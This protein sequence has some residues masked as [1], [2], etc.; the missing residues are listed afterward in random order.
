MAPISNKRYLNDQREPDA[1]FLREDGPFL[2]ALVHV[3]TALAQLLDK[4]NLAVPAPVAGLGLIDTGASS[5]CIHEPVLTQLGLNPIG[6][7]TSRTAAGIAIQR[8]YPVRIEFPGEGIDREFNSVAGVDLSGQT[9]SLST[10]EQQIIALIG[11]D[12][13]RNWVLIYNGPI[14]VVTIAF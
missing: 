14:G 1:D 11:R 2:N 9:V 8:L 3:P 5:T 13:M 7:T 4:Q 12:M 6:T 10:G